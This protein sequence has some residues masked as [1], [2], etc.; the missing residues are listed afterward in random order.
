MKGKRTIEI[1]C[2]YILMVVM[3]ALVSLQACQQ[4]NLPDS[5]AAGKNTDGNGNP[6]TK[7][8]EPIGSNGSG[9]AAADYDFAAE[10]VKVG[11]TMKGFTVKKVTLNPQYGYEEIV[12]EGKATLTGELMVNAVGE[13]K[14]AFAI[15]KQQVLSALPVAQKWQM[16]QHD[17]TY[18]GFF[19]LVNDDTV[20]AAIG[21]ERD[22]RL[23]E[24]ANHG[25]YGSYKATAEFDQFVYRFQPNTDAASTL[26]LAKLISIE[27]SEISP[28]N[29]EF[30]E[31]QLLNI[32]N[33]YHTLLDQRK[34]NHNTV[35]EL[36]DVAQIDSIHVRQAYID[37][38]LHQNMEMQRMM[39]LE[40]PI[41]YKNMVDSQKA[42][43]GQIVGDYTVTDMRR[44]P[45]DLYGMEEVS[46]KFS[47]A[48]Y[49]NAFI[50]YH[51][52]EGV[53]A[54]ALDPEEVKKLP[55]TYMMHVNGAVYQVENPGTLLAKIKEA[56]P[57]IAT[58]QDLS[59]YVNVE[60]RKITARLRID[61]LWLNLGYHA[62]VQNRVSV[63]DVE[64]VKN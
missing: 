39:S 19:Y 6:N 60:D 23:S 12:F 34:W 3:I 62:Y 61:D 35:E 52:P 32:S 8:D 46:A 31:L 27:A 44:I 53:L 48:A 17:D 30:L 49:V 7:S 20:I 18:K 37:Q 26:E 40:D 58:E 15:D 4:G 2:I 50:W 33:L 45:R 5:G 25:Y 51:E 29:K 54:V 13:S 9:G 42:Y 43:Y 1:R 16:E 56:Y 11:D 10:K 38:L 24:L 22:W 63:S 55:H 41:A 14:Y 36:Q 47:G 21:E 64:I 28:E 59:Q 57:Q